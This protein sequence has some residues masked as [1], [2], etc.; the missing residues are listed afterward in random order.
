MEGEV[1]NASSICGPCWH[2]AENKDRGGH[3]CQKRNGRYHPLVISCSFF[4][5]EKPKEEEEK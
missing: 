4:T 2:G 1:N 5:K 3:N